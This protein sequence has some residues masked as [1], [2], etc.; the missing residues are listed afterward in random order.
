M[1]P[2]SKRDPVLWRNGLHDVAR[3][4][5]GL[6]DF[7]DEAYFE[8]L[9]VLFDAYSESPYLSRA[10][11]QVIEGQIITALCGRL[12]SEA[13]WQRDGRWRSGTLRRPIFILGLPRTGTTALHKLLACDP[14]HQTLPH[15]LGL[16][17]IPRP[18]QDRWP[19]HPAYQ[20]TVARLETLFEENPGLR[21]IHDMRADEADECRLLRMQSLAD[22]TFETA[23]VP[24]Y[25][26]WLMGR[27]QP[28]VYA[29]YADNL[30]LV[31]AGD[32]RRW[33]LKCPG[34][35]WALDALLAEFP[36]ACIV[37]T[38]RAPEQVIP[39]SSSLRLAGARS[40]EPGLPPEVVGRDNLDRWHTILERAWAVRRVA[41]KE[42]FCDV[43]YESLVA[44][45]LEQ[46]RRIYGHFGISLSQAAEQGMQA[47][48]AARPQKHHGDHRYSAQEFGLSDPEI[49]ERFSDYRARHGLR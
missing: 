9:G 19:E 21:A 41:Q 5:S 15:W 22:L 17:P 2:L 33:V 43:D 29:R 44:D 39:S 11:W 4:R 36:D 40:S 8:A 48:H 46:V 3:E 18:P 30:R 14:A 7:G 34:H 37:Q 42:Q 13:G 12:V 35:L 10:G 20:E 45:P 1:H 27:S 38:H 6:S 16:H 47:W 49:R 25:R 26:T 28:D 23:Y 32:E 31:G 24:R